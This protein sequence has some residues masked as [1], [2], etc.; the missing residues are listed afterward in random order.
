MNQPNLLSIPF[1]KNAGAS[2]KNEIPDSPGPTLAPQQ[3]TWEEGFPLVTMQP[4]TIGGIPPQGGDFNGVL[5]ALSEHTVYQNAGGMYKFNAELAA[6]IGG[7]SKG[8]VLIS[9]DGETLYRSLVDN[10]LVNPNVSGVGAE[11]A[12]A[13]ADDSLRQDLA[14]PDGSQLM[15]FRASLPGAVPRTQSQENS[16]T[17]NIRWWTGDSR[18]NGIDDLQT[19][20]Q[21]AVT[22]AI[23]AGY[24]KME[25][26]KGTYVSSGN[27][28]GFHQLTHTGQGVIKRGDDIWFITPRR[29]S[30]INRI[31]I[32]ASAAGANDGLSPSQ[33]TTPQTALF[34]AWEMNSE[35][36]L[37]GSWE[38]VFAEGVFTYNGV[39]ASYAPVFKNPLKII[40][41][42]D[43][44]T[45]ESLSIWRYPGSSNKTAYKDESG[46]A[47]KNIIFDGVRFENWPMHAISILGQGNVSIPYVEVEN[48]G[49]EGSFAIW[50]RNVRV[51]IPKGKISNCPTGV[52]VQYSGMYNI[53]AS[54]GGIAFSDCTTGVSIGRGSK[55]HVAHNTF[56]RMANFCIH[57]DQNS[58]LRTI[59]NDFN[60]FGIAGINLG[61]GAVWDNDANERDTW[62]GLEA[63]KPMIQ[64]L[65]GGLA[66]PLNSSGRTKHQSANTNYALPAGVGRKLVSYG[67]GYTATFVFL[68]GT[69]FSESLIAE[70]TY[71]VAIQNLQGATFEL[72]MGSG[73]GESLNFD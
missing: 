71:Y 11:W 30:H 18:V 63:G 48:C 1:A 38:V 5:N 8:A 24:S 4:P 13:A 49:A 15:S 16:D 29:N 39:V 57:A 56:D 51:T 35:K 12:N 44:V 50:T 64:V 55:G 46:T 47:N 37:N 65:T 53:G 20:I 28:A 67:E 31:Y 26:P 45:G 6:A 23:N 19:E 42:R 3:A 7:Y 66:R 54:G 40:G 10:N 52:C 9:D 14:S 33:P 69:L 21:S 59:K 36:A 32:G 58:R 34:N 72:A 73:G 2:T 62:A 17:A 60:S 27:I 68:G 43:P 61:G 25:W 22:E 70:A 41:Q